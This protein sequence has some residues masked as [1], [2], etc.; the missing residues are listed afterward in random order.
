MQG[1]PCDAHGNFLPP[2]APPEPQPDD[3][4]WIPFA[5]RPSFEFTELAFEEARMSKGTVNRLLRILAAKYIV[6]NLPA[7]YHPLFR[8]YQDVLDAIDTIE[9]GE[10]SWRTFAFR[11]NGPVYPDSPSWK[12]ETYLVHCR[13]A[14][15][16]AENL[17]ASADFNSRFD[18]VPY[19]EFTGPGCRRV[20]N[21]MSARWA[22]KQAV[23]I[24]SASPI[25]FNSGRDSSAA[26]WHTCTVT[27]SFLDFD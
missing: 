27:M 1:R 15:R 6:D 3:K 2:N 7:D 9:Y 11:F 18:Y 17:A 13:D 8:K 12:R 25:P 22:Y 21:L 14:L 5:D 26:S 10:V 19:E 16:V 4:D 23:S 20:A 24:A